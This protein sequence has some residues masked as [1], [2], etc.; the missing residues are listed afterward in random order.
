MKVS[1]NCQFEH[2]N[3]HCIDDRSCF[4]SLQLILPLRLYCHYLLSFSLTTQFSSANI[5]VL[6]IHNPFATWRWYN[7]HSYAHGEGT[8]SRFQEI[9]EKKRKKFICQLIT[10]WPKRT[11]REFFTILWPFLATRSLTSNWCRHITPPDL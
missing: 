11:W 5:Q 9:I 1:V 7:L 3:K 6:S 10:Y 8:F 4:L 2:F